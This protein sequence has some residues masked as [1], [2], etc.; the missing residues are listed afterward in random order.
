MLITGA[1]VL[2]PGRPHPV[3]TDV[4]VSGDR[5]EA[6][7]AATVEQHSVVIDAAGLLLAAGLIDVHGDAFERSLMPRPGVEVPL[8][9]ALV[10]N[11]QQL[12]A[13]G[14]TTSFLS[15]TDSWEPGLR[16][17][18]TLRRLVDA[19]ASRTGAPRLE[20]HVR[21]ERCNTDDHDELA[22]WVADGT[23]GMLSYNDHT[24]G[25]IKLVKGAS[26]TRV[27]RPGVDAATF[28]TI[29]EAA[30]TRRDHVAEQERELATIAAGADCPTASHDAGGLDDL[31]RDLALGVD[32][33]EFPMSIELSAEYQRNDIAIRRRRPPLLR[34][35]LPVAVVGAV[36]DGGSRA[37]LAGPSVGGRVGQVRTDR[38][39]GKDRGGRGRRSDSARRARRPDDRFASCRQHHRRRPRRPRH[40]VTPRRELILYATPTRPL[41]DQC[42]TFF[43]A[44]ADLGPTSAQLYPPHC[45]LTG[46]FRR[47]HALR[48]SRR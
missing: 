44:A 12:L 19:L 46:F 25:G 48:G 2:L 14:I 20:L 30:I 13:S 38:R 16:S 7:G 36:C 42:N 31:E 27:D 1:A 32:I 33:A 40:L 35:P 37:L 5:I 45:T 8:D 22:G 39:S 29:M 6:I 47:T 43:E 23:I 34:L 10:D 28:N 26:P 3:E 11:D 18:P 15:A 21:H 17:R 9:M 24:P 41:A 4:L